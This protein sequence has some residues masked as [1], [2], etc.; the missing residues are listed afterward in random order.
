MA[1]TARDPKLYRELS[2]PFESPDEANA[3]VEA[4]FNDLG[5]IR[6]KHGFPD[7]ICVISGSCVYPDGEE[8]NFIIESHHGDEANKVLLAGWLYANSQAEAREMLN[9]AVSRAQSRK[10][11]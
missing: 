8:G 2:E 11:S 4:F 5:E 3:A 6:K 10:E 1:M 7:V 9:K